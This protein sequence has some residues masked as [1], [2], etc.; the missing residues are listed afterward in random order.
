MRRLTKAEVKLVQ[1]LIGPR[2]AVLFPGESAVLLEGEGVMPT[3]V[4]ANWLWRL[5]KTWCK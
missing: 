1:L 5:G 2:G 4:C 3:E